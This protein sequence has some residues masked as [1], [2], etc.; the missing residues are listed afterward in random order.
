MH[1]LVLPRPDA[2]TII[3]IIIIIVIIIIIIIQVDTAAVIMGQSRARVP[4]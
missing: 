1:V 2:T 3:I 4:R